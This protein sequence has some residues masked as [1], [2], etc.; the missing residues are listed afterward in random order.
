MIKVSKTKLEGV[1]LIKPDIFSDHR[2][3][4]TEIYNEA[5]YKKNG[6]VP[7]F[8]QDD[9]VISKKNV[10]RGIHGDQ[11]T[12]KL[13]SCLS[14]EFFLA[15]INCDKNSK[16]FGCWQSFILSDKNRLQIL[17]PPKYGNGHL[18]LSGKTA[19]HYKQ[20]TYYNRKAQFTY[21]WDEPEFNITWPIKN[22][23]LSDRDKNVKFINHA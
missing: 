11:K 17:V 2:G 15:V 8:I 20:S 18:V 9:I 5:L 13:I 4:Y 10:L 3:E 22:P 23:I 21:R 12:W 1:L 6:I 7:D 19:F 14:G 16:K